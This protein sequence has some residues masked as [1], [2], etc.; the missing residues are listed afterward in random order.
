MIEEK[1][2]ELAR[3]RLELDKQKTADDEGDEKEI[4]VHTGIPGVDDD[5]ED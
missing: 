5:G 2:L 3:E 1:K 4:H